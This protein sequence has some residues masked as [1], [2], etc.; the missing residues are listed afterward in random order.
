MFG[1]AAFRIAAL[2]LAAASGAAAQPA[3]GPITTASASAPPP[4]TEATPGPLPVDSSSEG[5]P[6]PPG[7]DGKIHGVVSVGVGTGGYREGSISA[8]GPLPGG[9]EAS[10][11]VGDVQADGS[12]SRRHR[13]PLPPGN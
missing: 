2:T 8:S 13:P 3:D 1:R 10:I 6:L 12:P 7:P 4:S 5:L 11:F 9:G